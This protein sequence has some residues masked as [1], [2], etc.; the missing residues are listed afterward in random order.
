[1]PDI[2]RARAS[3]ISYTEEKVFLSTDGRKISQ[4]LTYTGAGISVTAR[5]PNDAQSRSF[6]D[7]ASSGYE[8][9]LDLDLKTKIQDLARGSKRTL[10][11]PCLS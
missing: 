10:K 11:R 1:M 8:F 7:Y 9:V 3:M 2:S 5:G 4:N 6:D